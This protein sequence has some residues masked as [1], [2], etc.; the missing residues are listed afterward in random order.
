[1]MEKAETYRHRLGSTKSRWNSNFTEFSR[2]QQQ[3]MA[4]NRKLLNGK[5]K[6]IS[7]KIFQIGSYNSEQWKAS[8]VEIAPDVKLFRKFLIKKL[9]LSRKKVTVKQLSASTQ[10]NRY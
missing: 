4:E 8:R 6:P 5:L 2:Q 10:L 3:I 9:H 1:M 7:V